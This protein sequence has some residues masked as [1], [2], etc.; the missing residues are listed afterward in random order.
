[1]GSGRFSS[2]IACGWLFRHSC[3]A[4][5]RKRLPWRWQ[6]TMMLAKMLWTRAP[7]RFLLQPPTLR[8]DHG[9]T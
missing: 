9:R 3:R 4:K 5:S 8:A 6:L 7:M 1:M 2:V